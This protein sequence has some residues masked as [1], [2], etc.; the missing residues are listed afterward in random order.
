MIPISSPLKDEPTNK[1]KGE[2]QQKKIWN[3]LMCLT[4]TTL[5]KKIQKLLI[6]FFFL[7]SPFGWGSWCLSPFSPPLLFYLE[8]HWRVK[9]KKTVCVF[10]L[11]DGI[12]LNSWHWEIFQGLK[13]KKVHGY[14]GFLFFLFFCIKFVFYL[15]SRC[16]F[17][18]HFFF[19]ELGVGTFFSACL[20]SLANKYLNFENKSH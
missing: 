1:Q 18:F 10:F 19:W 11:I 13:K 4:L 7:L 6:R 8:H 9:Q 20:T 16:C 15:L 12:V 14:C 2:R 5:K 3:N 17:R